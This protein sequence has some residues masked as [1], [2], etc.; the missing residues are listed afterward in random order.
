VTTPHEY[1]QGLAGR[2]EADG[3]S[4]QWETG[5]TPLL[6]G[7]RSDFRLQWFATR[8]HV[9][10]LATELSEITVPI[11]DQ[12][13]EFAIQGALDRKTGLPPGFQTG[14]AVFP[15]MASDRVDPA[16][17]AH[18][19]QAQKLRFAAFGRPTVIDTTNRVVGTYRGTPALGFIYAGYLRKKSNL[20]FPAPQ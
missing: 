18:A 16:A 19:A 5:P 12:F 14:V 11:V 3:C 13:S 2:L 15:V 1:L 6:V 7:R 10:V 9:F 8:L 4:P 20:Y 17:V